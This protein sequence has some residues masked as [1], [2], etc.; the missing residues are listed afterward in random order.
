MPPPLVLD[1]RG[2]C[3]PASAGL[4]SMIVFAYIP[5]HMATLIVQLSCNC[6]INHL[7]IA[8]AIDFWP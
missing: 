4:M 6:Q 2:H 1:L 5:V 8:G 3:P 7:H